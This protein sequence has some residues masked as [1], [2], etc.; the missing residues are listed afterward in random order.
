MKTIIKYIKDFIREDFNPFVYIYFTIFLIVTIYVNYE[1]DFEDSILDSYQQTPL[2]FLYYTL[3]Y[4][5]AYYS[6]A[7][8]RALFMRR[9]DILSDYRFW[10]KSILFLLLIGFA[11]GFH[12]HSYLL[13][14]F[15]NSYE[16]YYLY[17]ILIN[18]KRVCLYS[19]PLLLI[20]IIFDR[21]M[22]GLYGLTFK[23][24]NPKPYFIMLLIIFPLIAGASFQ[25]DFV[26]Y[27]PTLKP[28]SVGSVFGLT[29][30]QLS[31]IYEFFYGLDFVFVEW[32][33]RGALALGMAT[34]MG[35]D[36]LLPMVATYAFLHFGK[37]AGETISSVFGGYILGIIAINSRSI[38]GG[39]ILHVGV[40]YIMDGA[41]LIQY[42]L[43]NKN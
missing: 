40:A 10:I 5:F 27:Y 2:S 39:V 36:A 16:R 23:G 41:A 20:K 3:F 34:V 25:A 9:L 31:V 12:Y 8:P 43:L 42:Y 14:L 6:I 35:K 32:I 21:N 30:I 28:W 33:F 19:I 1:L 7:I 26:S 4:A 29:K 22:K 38:F 17:K 13:D 24:F 18:I 11:A 15:E 37:P